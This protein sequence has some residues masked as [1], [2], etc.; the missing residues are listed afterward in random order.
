MFY[1]TESL[2][3]QLLWLVS[4]LEKAENDGEYVHILAHI[5]PSSAYSLRAWSKSYEHIVKRFSHIISGQ[6]FGHTHFDEWTVSFK[7]TPSSAALNVAWTA[8]S[9]T[10]FIGL[11]SNYRLNYIDSRTFVSI[12]ISKY[13]YFILFFFYICIPGCARS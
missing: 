3:Q 9:G 13:S 11:N 10:S 12:F 1:E 7:D 8:G 5:P 6:F 2:H 4:V